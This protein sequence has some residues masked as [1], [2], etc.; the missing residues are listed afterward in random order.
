MTDDRYARGGH[1]DKFIAGAIKHPGALH[2]EL[3]VPEG[4]KIPAK[5]LE[6]A[7]HSDNPKEARRARFAEELRSFHH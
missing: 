2:R 7:T 1:V 5:K 4:E 3:H 6:K